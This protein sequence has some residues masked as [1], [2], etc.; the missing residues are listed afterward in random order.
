[1]AYWLNFAFYDDYF[2]ESCGAPFDI[3]LTVVVV[4]SRKSSSALKS[5]TIFPRRRRGCKRGLYLLLGGVGLR[6]TISFKVEGFL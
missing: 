3:A 1:M 2:Q 6:V 5:M 4:F